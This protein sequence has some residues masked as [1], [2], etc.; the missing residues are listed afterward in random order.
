MISRKHILSKNKLRQTAKIIR[1]FSLSHFLFFSLSIIILSGCSTK[2]KTFV[3]RTWH[4]INGKYNAFFYAK[5]SIKEGE[6]ILEKAHIEDYRRPLPVY[7]LADEKAAKSIYPQMDKAYQKSSKVITR[8]SIFIKGQEYCKW[9]DENYMC[10]GQSHYYKRDYFAAIEVFVYVA[11]QYKKSETRYDAWIWLLRSYNE[12]G[13]VSK[14]LTLIEQLEGDK[15]FPKKYKIDYYA[16]VADFYMKREDYSNAIKYLEKA[17]KLDHEAINIKQPK[18]LTKEAATLYNY[19]SHKK[20]R[21]RLTY[22]LAQLYEKDGE[23][24]KAS[25]HY[26]KVIK[27]HPPYEMEFQAKIHQALSFRGDAK[28]IKK[29]LKK[30]LKDTRNKDYFDQIY[31]ALAEISLKEND[32]PQAI[33]YLKLS[34]ENNTNNINQKVLSYLKLADTHFS[35][36]D[37]E[38]ASAYYDSTAAVLP[39]DFPDYE[40]IMN[41]KNSLNSL[42]KNLKI[43][44]YEDSVQRVAKMDEKERN[45]FLD[46]IID[47]LMKEEEEKKKE[48]KGNASAS[49]GF[50]PANPG[51]NLPG[52]T[53]D[54]GGTG[55]NWYFNNPGTVSYGIAEFTKKWGDRKLEDNWRRSKKDEATADNP[56]VENPENLE[57][58]DYVA[59]EDSIANAAEKEIKNRDKYLKNLPLSDE[60]MKQSNDTIIEAYYTVASIYKENLQDHKNAIK[61]FEKLIERYPENKYL[62]PS[63]YQLYRTNLEIKNEERANYY[64]NILLDKYPDSEYSK[65]IRNPNHNRETQASKDEIENFYAATYENYLDRNYNAVLTNCTKAEEI[66]AKSAYSAKFELLKAFA[67]GGTTGLSAYKGSLKEVIVKYPTD[68]VKTKAEEILSILDGTKIIDQKPDTTKEKPSIYKLNKDTLHNCIIFVSKKVNITELKIAISDFNATYFSNNQYDIKSLFLDTVQ[69]VVV[70]RFENSD[71][72]MKYFDV[73]TYDQ[74]IMEKSG[75][76]PKFFTITD[77][78]YVLLFQEKNIEN[79]KKFFEKKY[80]NIN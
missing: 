77:E 9:I 21:T 39:K 66:Y 71:K 43:I 78:N 61:T 28:N 23:E 13:I 53:D 22:I 19:R 56:D 65:I 75:I 18:T 17:T 6:G 25:Q 69:V 10:I 33:E 52:S 44:A 1:I 26:A 42:V 58:S 74:N 64:K 59:K 68:P 73:I 5:E 35:V 37:Y 49:Q 7:Q 48:K 79:Y 8:H 51:N 60:K 31:Y 45:K 80:L 24:S 29:T 41:K 14:A 27:M 76:N 32:V 40:L 4:N 54:K 46:K 20:L 34:L 47:K 3:H 15:K 55:S 38:L 57:N 62:L 30:M 72:A 50:G 2:K 70:E 12:A 36:P 67:V 63:Y 11:K 16:A